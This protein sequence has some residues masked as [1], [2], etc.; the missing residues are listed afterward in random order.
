MA[1][2]IRPIVAWTYGDLGDWSR[3][4]EIA[5]DGLGRLDASQPEVEDR[6]LRGLLLGATAYLHMLSGD[7]TQ[8]EAYLAEAEKLGSETVMEYLGISVVFRTLIKGGVRLAWGD[9]AEALAIAD[10]D[11]SR[12]REKDMRCYLPDVL[13]TRGEALRGLGRTDEALP[14]LT[15]ARYEAERQ[16]SRRGLWPVLANLA[17]LQEER[18]NAAEAESLRREARRVIEYIADHADALGLREVFT[19][20]PR[21]RAVLDAIPT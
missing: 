1:A 4:L 8:A 6:V 19:S 3:G 21:V 7:R 11:L 10:D 13:R 20:T 16:G 15:E 2:V 18:G 17:E 14:S 5:A 12:M 9:F